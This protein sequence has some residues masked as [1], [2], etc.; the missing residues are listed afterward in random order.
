M[1]DWIK[2]N[3]PPAVYD[4]VMD[5]VKIMAEKPITELEKQ[6]ARNISNEELMKLQQAGYFQCV[7]PPKTH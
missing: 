5:K 4:A 6:A 7:E 2:E 1:L 3:K